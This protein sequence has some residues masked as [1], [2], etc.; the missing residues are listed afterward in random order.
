[1]TT[2]NETSQEL[3]DIVTEYKDQDDNDILGKIIGIGVPFNKAKGILDKIMVAQGFRMT[4]V[5]LDSKAE[6]ILSA[7]SVTAETTSDEVAEQID[8][9]VEE[10][11]CTI[12]KARNY[13]KAVFTGADIAYPKATYASSGPR[14]PREPGYRGDVKISADFAL[15]NPEALENDQ[16]SFKEYMDSHGGSTTKTGSDKSARWYGSVVDLRIFG[17]QWQAKHC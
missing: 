3:I 14:A 12:T 11:G 4:K 17:K 5:E 7:F 8:N 1:M 15:E 9:L 2:L 6:E 13:V 10:L 16:E